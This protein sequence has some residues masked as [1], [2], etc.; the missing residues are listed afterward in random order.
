MG[1]DQVKLKEGLKP[2]ML[3]LDFNPQEFQAWQ[4]KF[5]IYHQTL[6]MH[7]ADAKEQ[8]DLLLTLLANWRTLAHFQSSAHLPAG[9]NIFH[10]EGQ[11][12]EACFDQLTKEFNKKYPLST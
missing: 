4:N 3:T 7:T 9:A 11:E 8:R 2:T 12:D 6:R 1:G 10:E 5:R